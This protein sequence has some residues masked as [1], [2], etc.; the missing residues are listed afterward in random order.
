MAS[1]T[2]QDA[3]SEGDEGAMEHATP[4]YD[5]GDSQYDPIRAKENAPLLDPASGELEVD[6]WEM[7]GETNG[8]HRLIPRA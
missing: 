7:N 5:A 4:Q 8:E 1:N 3:I 6:E 2:A